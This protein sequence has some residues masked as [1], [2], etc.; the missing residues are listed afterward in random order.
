MKI[1]LNFIVSYEQTTVTQIELKS[2]TIILLR[3]SNKIYLFYEIT[4][5]VIF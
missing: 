4:N 2:E 3:N 5:I 1:T